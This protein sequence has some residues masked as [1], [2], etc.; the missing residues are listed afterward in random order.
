MRYFLFNI[1][2]EEKLG[3]DTL[4]C[5]TMSGSTMSKRK[6]ALRSLS[7]NECG[8]GIY[9]EPIFRPDH[10]IFIVFFLFYEIIHSYF[11][12]IKICHLLYNL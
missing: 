10:K 4:H 5:E 6:R 11:N 2:V 12:G 3:F 9:A 7:A 1:L 8:A